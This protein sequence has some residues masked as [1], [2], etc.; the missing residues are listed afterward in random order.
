MGVV[1]HSYGGFGGM[2]VVVGSHEGLR[3]EFF[4]ACLEMPGHC[5]SAI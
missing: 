2:M 5:L 4:V 3:Q 1:N